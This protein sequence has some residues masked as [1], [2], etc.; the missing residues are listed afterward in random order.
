MSKES[1]NLGYA[2]FDYRQNP[3]PEYERRLMDAVK[4]LGREGIEN[5]IRQTRDFGRTHR[6]DVTLPGTS[7]R[8]DNYDFQRKR[9]RLSTGPAV[10]CIAAAIVHPEVGAG[11][12]HMHTISGEIVGKSILSYVLDEETIPRIM[13]SSDPTKEIIRR[14]IEHQGFNALYNTIDQTI[15][16]AIAQFK[17]L[18][19]GSVTSGIQLLVGGIDYLDPTQIAQVQN[20]I[21]SFSRDQSFQLTIQDMIG[22]TCAIT[23]GGPNDREYSSPKIEVF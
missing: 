5:E 12:S 2:M 11:M 21:R 22:H 8:R 10:S 6:A 17:K 20:H 1:D 9:R 15:N 16:N 4:R 7:A 14:A 23:Y 18:P 13:K 3:I 19:D